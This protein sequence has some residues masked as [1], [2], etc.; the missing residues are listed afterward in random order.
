MRDYRSSSAER[1]HRTLNAV[2]D[3]AQPEYVYALQGHK[4]RL[5]SW[6]LYA[7]MESTTMRPIA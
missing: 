5:R 4:K 6:K 1:L 3:L 2:P 7:L